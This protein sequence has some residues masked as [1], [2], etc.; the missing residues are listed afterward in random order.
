VSF[1]LELNDNTTVTLQFSRRGTVT[2]R[3]G[4]VEVVVVDSTGLTGNEVVV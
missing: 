4:W 3:S 2:C 1:P